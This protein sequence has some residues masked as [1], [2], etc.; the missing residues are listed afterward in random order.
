[1]IEARAPGKLVIVGEYAVLHGAPG[2]AVAV[3]VPARAR[4]QSRP[5]PDSELVI[6][7]TG[8]R[9]GFRWNAAGDVS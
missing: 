7:D 4:L 2:I 1:M 6:P 3:D 5:G 9:F 8:E